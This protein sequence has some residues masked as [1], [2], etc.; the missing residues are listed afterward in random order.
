[1]PIRREVETVPGSMWTVAGYLVLLT[2]LGL[3]GYS[4]YEQKLEN[5]RLL[6]EAGRRA[7]E[8]EEGRSALLNREAAAARLKQQIQ[9]LEK[10]KA[11]L[12]RAQDEALKSQR[13]MQDE[14]RSA[15]ASKDVTISEL[16]GKLTLNIL[17]RIL[18]DSGQAVIKPEGQEVLRQIAGVLGQFPSN[19]IH[20]TGHT[21]NVPIHTAQFPSNW[22]LSSA[23]AMAAVR[24][25]V[26]EAGVN[27]NRLAAVAHGEFQPV[28]SNATSE[29]RAR[30]RRI[31]IIVLPEV[32][33]VPERPE[34]EPVSPANSGSNGST[35]VVKEPAPAVEEGPPQILEPVDPVIPTNSP[36]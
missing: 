30:N 3:A 16:Q 35:N 10:D 26:E 14:M 6:L 8:L 19:Q 11:D 1:M 17:D 2:L 12:K 15:I 29:G 7:A 5:D 34:P 22:E 13:S 20:V 25:L 4:L 28:A 33:K 36:N 32:F 9:L 23:R 18:F 24:F 27:P 31:A 21:D